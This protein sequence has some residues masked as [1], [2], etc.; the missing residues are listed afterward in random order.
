[1]KNNLKEFLES[2]KKEYFIWLKNNAVYF[3]SCC[4]TAT[5]VIGSYLKVQEYDIR[6]VYGK[7][8]RF[9]NRTRFHMWLE[10]NNEV[11]DFTLFQFYIGSMQ[12]F[13]KISAEDTYEYCIKEIQRGD[14]I[15]LK[16]YYLEW[17][18]EE[19][20]EKF[21]YKEIAKEAGSFKEYLMIV[22]NILKNERSKVI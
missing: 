13:K 21:S 6:R 4:C 3:P 15:F 18:N 12:K 14:I 10:I 16:E 8:K 1:M 7:K 2:I 9:A 17:F 22:D 19:G 20:E 5:D 11:I